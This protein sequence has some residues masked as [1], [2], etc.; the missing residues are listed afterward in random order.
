[1]GCVREELL[2]VVGGAVGGRVGH[3][4]GTGDVGLVGQQVAVDDE[5]L[6]IASLCEGADPA[7]LA[8]A[9]VAH[10]GGHLLGAQVLVDEGLEGAVELHGHEMWSFGG[11]VRL[12]GYA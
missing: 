8:D 5:G 3:E 4:A 7:G 2:A 9:G 6:G 10:Q 11:M 12:G 1:M